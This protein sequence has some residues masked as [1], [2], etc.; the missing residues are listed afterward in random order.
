VHRIG[1]P[2]VKRGRQGCVG[3]HNAFDY[4]GASRSTSLNA[5]LPV[6]GN[7]LCAIRAPSGVPTLYELA[8]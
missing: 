1:C 6:L 3:F 4:G 2:Q 5:V 8:H 7:G